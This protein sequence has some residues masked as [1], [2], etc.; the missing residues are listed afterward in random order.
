[1]TLHD[2]SKESLYMQQVRF[3]D[4]E[5]QD[6]IAD[7]AAQLART[8]LSSD[9]P[10]EEQ[11]RARVE[12]DLAEKWA[13]PP[14]EKVG[15]DT[16]VS[17]MRWINLRRA[18]MADR[19]ELLGKSI[20]SGLAD[21][22]PRGVNQSVGNQVTHIG[23][24][25]ELLHE[26]TS[27]VTFAALANLWSKY[28]GGELKQLPETAERKS[29]VTIFLNAVDRI[30]ILRE[31]DLSNPALEFE[32]NMNP[33]VRMVLSRTL[34]SKRTIYGL[35]IFEAPQQLI[36]NHTLRIEEDTTTNEPQ[37]VAK[38]VGRDSAP[39]D[40]LFNLSGIAFK[41]LDEVPLERVR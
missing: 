21:H 23:A 40:M 41:E 2:S 36:P 18:T 4:L 34:K 12:S 16:A 26:G 14:M 9:V 25:E 8:A 31:E 38:N 24:I 3:E 10:I 29:A 28:V 22:A 11:A 19:V 5:L 17:A 13:L 33:D 20:D 35:D 27:V 32:F 1:M 37:A 30:F 6:R 7:M 39:P 15:F